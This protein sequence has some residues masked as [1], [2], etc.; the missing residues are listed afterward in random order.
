M[1]YLATLSFLMLMFV[2]AIAQ[3]KSAAELKNEGNDALKAKDYKT[4]LSLYEQAIASWEEEEMDAA[5]VYNTATC[6]R[7]IK[8]YDKAV[9]YFTQ[10]VELDYKA[11]ISTYYIASSLDK[12]DK[13]DEMVEVLVDGIEKYSTSKY[14]GHMK[15]MLATYYVKQSNALY[16]EGQTILNTRTA[17]NNDQWDSIKEKAKVVFDKAADFAN[18]ALE[19]QPTN[20]NAKTILAGIETMLAS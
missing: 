11:D 17:D 20:A 6:A 14:V 16:T 7:K 4:A 10:S 12:Q 5:M 3:D 9:K 8:D 13:E 1:R 2:G 18:K 15:K 19:V